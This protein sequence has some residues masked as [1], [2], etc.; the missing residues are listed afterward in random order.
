[1][2]KGKFENRFMENIEVLI[3]LS[4]KEVA[5]IGF[6]NTDGKMDSW[7]SW[8]KLIIAQVSETLVFALLEY[9]NFARK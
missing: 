8:C 4:E 9:G 5:A 1:M 3:F 2:E 7:F 6:S